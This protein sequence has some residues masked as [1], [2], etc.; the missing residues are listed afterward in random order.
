MSTDITVTVE[1]GGAGFAANEDLTVKKVDPDGACD[2][3][4]VIV[5]K[6]STS[7]AKSIGTLS[8][9]HNCRQ[10][11]NSTAHM[12]GSRMSRRCFA[13]DRPS[14]LPFCLLLQYTQMVSRRG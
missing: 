9:K 1:Q 3:A 13:I 7:I 10:R 14:P 2:E 12:H 5:C 6:N 8:H 11:V 4:G